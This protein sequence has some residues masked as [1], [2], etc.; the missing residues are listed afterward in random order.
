MSTT[1]SANEA[2]VVELLRAR[3]SGDPTA[4]RRL[5]ELLYA[6]LRGLARRK[7]GAER[8][9]HTLAPTSLVH[10][11]FLRL[12]HT[13]L[14]CEDRRDY[15]ALAAAVMKRILIDSARR[16]LH[17]EDVSTNSRES[18]VQARPIVERRVLA[19]ECALERLQGIDPELARVVELRFLLGLDVE[20]VAR[21]LERSTASIQRD[22]RS[23]R[24]FLKREIEKEDDR[25]R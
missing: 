7:L 12:E 20:A 2:E 18:R 13:S 16:R 23:A 6:E 17:R 19:L 14:T 8:R 10:E 15:L 9:D 11:V 4:G 3:R 1:T 22:W 25:E 24:A 5:F 21:L